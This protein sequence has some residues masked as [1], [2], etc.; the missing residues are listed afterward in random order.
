MQNHF[1]YKLRQWFIMI[2]L[3][4]VTPV[5][6]TFLARAAVMTKAGVQLD[7]RRVHRKSPP[8]VLVTLVGKPLVA[9]Q[10]QQPG[11]KSYIQ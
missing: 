3:S 4:D 10:W 7:G 9:V 2:F 5:G 8:S 6:V 1:K 11:V